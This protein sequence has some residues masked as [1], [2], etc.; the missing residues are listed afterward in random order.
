M[1]PF[2]GKKIAFFIPC[3][4]R[5]EGNFIF[6][7]V[8]GIHANYPDSD[9]VIVD[10]CSKEQHQD[11]IKDLKKKYGDKIKSILNNPAYEWGAYV[12]AHNG[13]RNKYDIIFCIQDSLIIKSKISLK[14]LDDETVL[15]FEDFPNDF[16]GDGVQGFC[17]FE[18]IDGY[19]GLGGPTMCVWNSFIITNNAINKMMDSEYFQKL[20]GPD[21]K[22]GSRFWERA[23][24]IALA[25]VNIKTKRFDDFIV[26]AQYTK[27][28]GGR[29]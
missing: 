8:E 17:N 19:N 29:G 26:H 28:F 15:T 6:E 11:Y 10:S 22:V 27:K 25:A 12:K 16:S 13:F 5:R 1:W 20:K 14:G 18:E 24:G 3:L 4:F 7:C 9:I 21:S 2:K 23:W